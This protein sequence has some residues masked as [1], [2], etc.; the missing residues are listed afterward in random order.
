MSE[1]SV[2]WIKELTKKGLIEF[3]GHALDRMIEREIEDKKVI[4]CILYG[5]VIEIQ[6]N[7]EDIHVLFQEAT[8]KNPEIYVVVAASYPYPVVVT[9]CKT[10]SEVWE[11]INGLLKRRS[12][13]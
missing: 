8:D 13:K 1:I 4:E 2:Q 10:D 3:S 9:V 11:E 6:T 7:F 5:K 12:K